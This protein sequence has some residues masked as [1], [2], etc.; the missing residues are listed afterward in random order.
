MRQVTVFTT[1]KD[2]HHFIQLTKS[3]Q[4]VKKIQTDE[5]EPTKEEVLKGIKQGFKELKLMKEGKMKGTSLKD[6]LNEL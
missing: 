1:N 5:D 6:F 4:Y 2:Y 3:L